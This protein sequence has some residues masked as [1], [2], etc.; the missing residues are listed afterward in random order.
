MPT[1]ELQA[2]DSRYATE[3]E[4]DAA[5]L[6][7]EQIPWRDGKPITIMAHQARTIQALRYGDAPIIINTAMTGDG[8]TLAGRLQLFNDKSWR[9]FSMYPTNEL[10]NDQ[11]RSLEEILSQT[12]WQPRIVPRCEVIDSPKIDD[13]LNQHEDLS[14]SESLQKLLTNRDYIMTNPDIFH[15]ILSFAY[16]QYGA[17]RDA[18]LNVITNRFHLFVFDEFHLFGVAQI[19]SVM[20]ALLLL[21]HVKGISQS[22]RFLFLSA[23]PQDLL[24]AM[25][26]RVD[27]QVQEVKGDYQHGLTTPPDDYRRILR[28]ATL[29]LHTGRLEDWV[30]AHFE[31]VILP[32]F[33]QQR[34]AAKGI[35]IANS[36]ATAHR[37]HAF[38]APICKSANIG[39]DINTGITPK[40]E[41]GH[42]VDLLVATSTVDVGVD[43]KINLLIFESMDA[44]S[45]TQRLGRLGRHTHSTDEH[46]FQQFAAHALLPGWVVDGL[47]AAY[48]DGSA[49]NRE[50]YKTTLEK[51]FQ[52][53]QGFEPYVHKW[54]G[55]QAAQVLNQLNKFEIKQQYE[56]VVEPLKQE[57]IQLFGSSVKKYYALHKEKQHATL[58][59]AASFRGGSP[60]TALQ[61]DGNKSGSEIVA[62]NLLPLL[63]NAELAAVD[64][65]TLYEEAERKGQSRRTLERGEPLAGY[66]RLGWLEKPRTVGIS[67][68]DDIGEER[69]S[70][71][72]EQTGFRF[73]VVGI[74]ELQRLNDELE[75]RLLVTLIIPHQDPDTLRRILRLGYQLEVL[76]F[77]Q[78]SMTGCAVFG[79]DA[80]LLDAVLHRYRQSNQPIIL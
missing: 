55:L 48:P 18:V 46:E 51:H 71:I 56:H 67:L 69:Y 42:D 64:L 38:L 2:V 47:T 75:T 36:V 52:P 8:K 4:M 39:L 1:L 10:A 21:R 53:F 77:R 40:K 74:P 16:R 7:P 28:S 78:G 33:A 73:E 27:I 13:Y 62:Y 50:C 76:R 54:A 68:S 70:T 22:P 3:E 9:T 15:L 12:D 20:L 19:S 72:I 32:F 44:A 58:D 80:L 41:R 25:A 49:V 11:A 6:T 30:K 35:I 63:L 31:D 66:R 26:R 59:A 45:H 79:R 23:T 60:F 24:L 57:S 61:T 65:E 37:V 17:A 43:F 5:K 29:H 14:R 34:P